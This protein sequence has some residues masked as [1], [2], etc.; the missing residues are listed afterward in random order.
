MNRKHFGAFILW[1]ALLLWFSCGGPGATERVTTEEV[2]K[3]RVEYEKGEIKTVKELIEVFTDERQ[4]MDSRMAALKALAETEHPDARSALQNYVQQ[5]QGINYGLLSAAAQ[6]LIKKETTADISAVVDGIASAQHKYTQ[7]RTNLMQDI[8]QTDIA[9]QIESLLKI[10]QIEKE[11]YTQMQESLTRVLGS[12]ADDRVI[13]ILINIAQ[14]KTL[15]PSVRSLALEV[16]GR[17][18]HPM[19]TQTFIEMLQDPDDQLRLHDFAL[20]AM[21]DI[22]ESRVILALLEAYNQNKQDYFYLLKTLTRA[23]GDFSDPE[24]APAL[25]E[26]AKDPQVPQTTRRDAIQ[27]LIKYQDAELFFQLLPLMEDPENYVLYDEMK[28]MAEA[29][30][31]PDL[32]QSLR[33]KALR[34]QKSIT[35][36]P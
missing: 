17:K 15:K 28:A 32:I 4:P 25:V 13:P 34:A 20:E 7:F 16:L 23:L 36:N 3:L 9:P 22:K 27:A 29:I 31:D 18:Q 24:V 2:E 35:G 12:V 5:A 19:I 8:K 11:N 14:D 26:I 21:G 33:A 30:G 6:Q 10:Y 1:A